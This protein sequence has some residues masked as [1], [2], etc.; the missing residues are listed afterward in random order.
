[1]KILYVLPFLLSSFA[2]AEFANNPDRVPSLGIDLIKG[3][4]AGLPRAG[5]NGAQTDGGTVGFRADLRYP[6]T[7]S[8]TIHTMGENIGVNN[9]KDFTEG[10]QLEVGMRVYFNH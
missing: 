4:V 3:Q 2:F 7:Q 6:I 9:N 8:I 1:M 5:V 10:Y